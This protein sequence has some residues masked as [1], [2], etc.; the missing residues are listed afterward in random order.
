MYNA[1]SYG[2][3]YEDS[4]IDKDSRLHLVKTPKLIAGLDTILT[5]IR[6]QE[7][8]GAGIKQP[9][10]GNDI[11]LYEMAGGSAFFAGSF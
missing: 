1:H 10:N 11:G 7:R 8:K 6:N 5:L 4:L 9:I 3:Y 2:S